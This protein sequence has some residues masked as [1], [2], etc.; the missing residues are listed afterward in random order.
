MKVQNP[1]SRQVGFGGALLTARRDIKPPDDLA[2][3]LSTQQRLRKAFRHTTIPPEQ[4][5]AEIASVSNLPIDQL[6]LM[7]STLPDNDTPFKNAIVAIRLGFKRL[8]KFASSIIHLH[9]TA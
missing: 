6:R 3:I 1:T 5:R 2:L 4:Q 8:T 7:A 9:H